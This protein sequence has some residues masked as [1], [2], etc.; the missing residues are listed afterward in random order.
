MTLADEKS[1]FWTIFEDSGHSSR[2][3]PDA[4]DG[5][6]YTPHASY[7]SSN[8]SNVTLMS[9][10]FMPPTSH[11][12]HIRLRNTQHTATQAAR[13]STQVNH[14][15]DMCHFESRKKERPDVR[16][17]KPKVFASRMHQSSNFSQT[18]SKR[19]RGA[20]GGILT[21]SRIKSVWI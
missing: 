4:M 3:C 10:W 13:T 8:V 19:Y 12:C 7:R 21:E 1:R 17:R 11:L 9:N 14:K 5:V 18:K 16:V 6:W 20:P 2:T 15:E